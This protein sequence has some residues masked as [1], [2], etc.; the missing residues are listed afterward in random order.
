MP[1][2]EVAAGLRDAD[3]AYEVQ[4]LAAELMPQLR[5]GTPPTWKSGGPSRDTPLTHA[6]LPTP[7]VMASPADAS[8]LHFNHRWIEAE[9]AL[10]LGADGNP[11]AMAVSIEIV[12]TRWDEGRGAPA[13]LKLA[14]LQSHGALVLGAWI[15]YVAKDWSKQHCEVR[16]GASVREFTGTHSL[17]DPAWLLPQWKAHV[18]SQGGVLPAGSVVTT[19]TWCGVLQAEKGDLVQVAFDGIGNASVQF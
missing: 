12:D 4:R 14:D 5:T 19:G 6:A 8:A 9:V 13:L 15:P 18:A 10:R 17:G 3:D 11:E 7:G 1:A 2:A 16:I